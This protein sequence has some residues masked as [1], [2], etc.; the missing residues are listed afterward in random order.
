MTG[1]KRREVISVWILNLVKNI[2]SKGR[3]ATRERLVGTAC[4]HFY[5]GERI[6]KEIL[7]HLI[8]S[9]KLITEYGEI[10]TRDFL[11]EQKA[12]EFQPVN[13]TTSGAGI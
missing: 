1:M 11:A 7:S 12:K 2:N 9:G 10:W 4:N 6:A 3:V 5:C 8:I 13:T